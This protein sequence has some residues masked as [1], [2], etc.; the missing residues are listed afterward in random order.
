MK[1]G[2]E[3]KIAPSSSGTFIGEMDDNALTLQE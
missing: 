2:N 1:F 3:R